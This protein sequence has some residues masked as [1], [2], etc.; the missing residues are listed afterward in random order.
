MHIEGS[1]YASSSARFLSE[2]LGN[3]SVRDPKD[4]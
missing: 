1:G 3:V 2:G 4:V